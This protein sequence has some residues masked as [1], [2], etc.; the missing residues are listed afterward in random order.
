[1]NKYCKKKF[2]SSFKIEN[3]KQKTIIGNEKK[4]ILKDFTTALNQH[5]S[6]KAIQLAIELHI[7]GFFDNL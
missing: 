4:K 3:L 1:M 2:L 5:D 6:N 7:S